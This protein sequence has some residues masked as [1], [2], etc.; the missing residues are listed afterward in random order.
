MEIKLLHKIPPRLP[1]PKGGHETEW[2]MIM[3]NSFLE[4]SRKM[5]LFGKEGS[6]EIS[7][8]KPCHFNTVDLYKKNSPLII[9]AEHHK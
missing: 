3:V 8:W 6:G 1:F 9:C 7:C 2:E 5:P 4:V